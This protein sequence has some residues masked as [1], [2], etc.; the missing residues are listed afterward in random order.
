MRVRPNSWPLTQ[1]PGWTP[2]TTEA[3]FFEIGIWLPRISLTLIPSGISRSQ[4]TFAKKSRV[5]GFCGSSITWAGV[6]DS[7]MTPSSMNTT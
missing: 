7:T 2:V 6:P 3:T 1:R 5:R 4:I